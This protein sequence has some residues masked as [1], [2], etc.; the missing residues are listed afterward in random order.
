M[1]ALHGGGAQ[2]RARRRSLALAVRLANLLILGGLTILIVWLGASRVLENAMSVGM[3]IA[4]IAYK[5]QFI[6]TGDHA[7]RSRGRP[8]HAAVHASGVADIALALPEPAE[9]RP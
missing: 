9:G 3:L 7:D 1:A 2:P 6:R 5:D 8:R 4:F